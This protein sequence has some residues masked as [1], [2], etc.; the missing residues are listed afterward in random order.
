[1]PSPI[2][3]LSLAIQGFDDVQRAKKPKTHVVILGAG[4]SG[5]ATAWFLKQRL[6]PQIDLTIIEKSARAGGWIQTID[7]QGFLFEQGPRSCRTAGNGQDT[8]ALIESIG[9]QKELLLP[10]S[11]VQDRYLYSHEGLQRLPRHLWE[12]P[13]NPLTRGW[14][15]ALWQDWTTPKSREEDETIHAFFSRR[16]GTAWTDRLVAPW[17]SGIYAGDSRRLS[18]RS[19]FPRLH[20]WEQQSGSLMRGAWRH[21]PKQVQPS[22]WSQS[23]ARHPLFSFRQGMEALPSALARNLASHLVLETSAIALNA[24]SSGIEVCLASGD[25]LWA[26]TLI[27]TL[28]TFA[29]APLIT[30]YSPCSAKLNE[31]PYATV[32]IVNMGFNKP[33]L[34]PKGFGYLVQPSLASPVLGCVWDSSLFPNHNRH[35]NQ[36]RLTMMLGGS[37]HPEIA[38]LSEPRVITH[39]IRAIRDHLEI[40]EE[41]CVIQAKKAQSAIPQ[42]EVGYAAWKRELHEAL[43]LIS[44]RLLLSGSAWSGVSINECVTQ[45]AELADAVHSHL[46]ES[47]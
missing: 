33:V 9:L 34:R 47:L 18:L 2:V 35:P 38:E 40:R 24:H 8:L 28:P 17:V 31:L 43:T 15:R 3:N 6:S 46:N 45:A 36:T 30:R 7:E 16:W 20:L 12:I 13:F 14:T 22:S 27:S 32:W 21:R 19:C 44:P 1:M 4:I 25:R 29:L 11:D 42:Y 5:L 39:A 23:I 10:S 26:D 37:R 41:P